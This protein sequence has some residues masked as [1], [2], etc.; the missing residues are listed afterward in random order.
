MGIHRAPRVAGEPYPGDP[1]GHFPPLDGLRGV[2]LLLILFHHSFH[3]DPG[4]SAVV[5]LIRKVADSTW[6]GVNLFFVLS[7]FLIGGILI[8]SRGEPGYFRTFYARRALRIFPL[9]YAFLL[10]FFF[11]ATPLSERLGMPLNRVGDKLPFFLYYSNLGPTQGMKVPRS[12]QP[13]WSLAVEEQVYLVWPAVI[14]LVSPRRLFRLMALLIPACLAW[15]VFALMRHGTIMWAYAFTPACLDAFAAGTI[16]ALLVRRGPDRETLRRWASLAFA[17]SGLFLAG[18]TIGLEGFFF[19]STPKAILTFGLT[20]LCFLFGGLI[21][22]LVTSPPDSIPN[23]LLS[24]RWLRDVGKY[25][26]AMYLLHAPVGGLIRALTGSRYEA[27]KG[28]RSVVEQGGFLLV[29]LLL[30]YLLAMMSWHL[31]EKPFLRLKS[32]FPTRGRGV[33]MLAVPP[34]Y[35]AGVGP[36]AQSSESGS[37][38]L[39][40][41]PAD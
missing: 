37:S 40:P 23:R 24:P 34:A 7:G 8:D 20:G 12:L 39:L 18:M 41:V 19:W 17:G 33:P 25:S 10:A 31:L 1:A 15:R 30:T 16:A 11:V 38:T 14:A 9:Y 22:L 5:G 28:L 13:V 29:T 6:V 2:A 32:Y 4:G 26:Y 27:A 3:P 36:P 35:E 21:L